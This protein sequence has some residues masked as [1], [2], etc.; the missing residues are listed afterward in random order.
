MCTT[1][2]SPSTSSSWIRGAVRVETDTRS[3]SSACTSLG[4]TPARSRARMST[5]SGSRS[6]M[7]AWPSSVLFGTRIESSPDASVV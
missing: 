5:A 2:S 6:G 1:T 3:F 7:I 4:F